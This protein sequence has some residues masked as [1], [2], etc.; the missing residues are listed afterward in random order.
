MA[1]AVLVAAVVLG[2]VGFVPAV[3]FEVGGFAR[4]VSITVFLALDTPDS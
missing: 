2:A 3:G 4:Q 1:S